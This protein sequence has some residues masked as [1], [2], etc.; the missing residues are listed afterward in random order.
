MYDEFDH[1][2]SAASD[3]YGVPFLWI[4]AII[5]TESSFNPNAYRAEPQINDASR[6]LMQVLEKTARGLGYAGPVEDLFNPAVSID[7]GT[8]LL[9]DLMERYGTDFREIYSA[10][11]SGSPTRYLTSSQVATNVQRAVT[12]LDNLAAGKYGDTFTVEA[13]S[14]VGLLLAGAA[15]LW[16]SSK[17]RKK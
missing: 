10:Y 5:G 12:W 17:G 3:Q 6:G 9:K 4:K 16:M 8:R 11:N 1:L 14:T 7:L 2:I 13:G 15:I